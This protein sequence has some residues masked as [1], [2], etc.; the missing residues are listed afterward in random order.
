V[1][2]GFGIEVV[3]ISAIGSAGRAPSTDWDS[4]LCDAAAD[5]FSMMVR[6]LLIR[7]ESPATSTPPNV[8]GMVGIAGAVRAIFTLRCST[9]SATRIASQML[10]V[11]DQE[12]AAYQCDAI[13][14]ICNMVAGQFKAKIGLEAECMLSLPTVIVGGDYELH[15]TSGGERLEVTAIYEDKPILLRLDVSR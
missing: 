9:E 14:E 3:M 7:S 6:A 4:I 2:A 11:S 13:G 15:S 10:M 1:A 8:T 12:A 5:V